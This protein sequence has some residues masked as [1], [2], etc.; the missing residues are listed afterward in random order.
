MQKRSKN[1]WILL[2]V[3]TVLLFVAYRAR[4]V[5]NPFLLAF[6]LAYILYPLVEWLE[7]KR[8]HR[9]F[10]IMALYVVGL[11]AVATVLFVGLP[12]VVDEGVSLWRST[13]QGDGFVDENKDGVWQKGEKV[14]P[15]LDRDR[16]WDPSYLSR[17]E[18]WTKRKIEG[19]NAAHPDKPV[20]ASTLLEKMNVLLKENT[21]SAAETGARITTWVAETTTSALSAGWALLQYAILVPLYMFFLLRGM[22]SIREAA[23]A[24]LPGRQREQFV[25]VLHRIHLAMS[26]FFRG[27]VL[28]CLAKGVLTAIGLALLDVRLPLLFGLIQAVSSLVPFVVLIV[29]WLPA[30]IFVLLDMGM[31]WGTILGVTAVY[32]VVEGLEGFVLTPYILG[33][34]TGLHPVVLILSLLVGGEL[35][36]MFGLIM[37]VPIVSILKILGQE[38]LLPPIRELAAETGKEPATS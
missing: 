30:I 24:H 16:R 25:H 36:G 35:F 22:N 20:E 10:T 27:K 3:F 2:L 18:T 32:L 9:T 8:I 17:A 5:L 15:D 29:G 34:E 13:F 21:D 1:I 38:Y 26:S 7:R 6:L 37:A 23:Y 11:G 12:L 31:S 4:A 19:W 33:K 14:R 28:I